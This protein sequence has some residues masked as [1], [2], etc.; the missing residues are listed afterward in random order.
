MDTKT[1]IHLKSIELVRVPKLPPRFPFTVSVIQALERLEFD[2]QVTFLVGENG[3]GK[4]TLLEGI[5]CAVGS[6]TVG[7][8]S[9]DRDRSLDDVR[10]L[11][12][13]LKLTWSVRT[14]RGFFMRAE[15]Y[16]NYATKM[17]QMREELQR[18]LDEVN[19]TYRD[20]SRT[21]QMY[22]RSAYQSQI[23][24]LEQYYGEGL[25]VRSHG[26]SFL[27][28]FQ[29]RFVPGGLYLLD[30]PEAPLS[31]LRQLS[32]LVLLKEMIAH[33]AQFIIATH[34]PIIMAFPGATILD[35]DGETIE[36]TLY[37]ELEHVRIMRG[38]LDH[39]DRYLAQLLD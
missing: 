34:S 22:A 39:P 31:P 26:E 37:D 11:G 25:D 14:R 32:F 19:E 8:E 28:F 17:A 6:I 27:D 30:E 33:D 24:A 7:S 10:P 12:K 15:D 20:R 16:F 4:S 36:E 35:F 1:G 18:D 38:F 13:Q 5:A 21:A 23:G 29:A 2:T 3:S 9:V